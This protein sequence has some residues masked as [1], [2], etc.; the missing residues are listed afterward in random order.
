MNKPKV[1]GVTGGI[2]AG[3][4][5]VSKIFSSLGV[6]VYDADSNAKLLMVS[7]EE[8]KQSII[9]LFGPESYINQDL[10]REWIG[11]KAFSNPDLLKQLNHLVHPAVQRHFTKWVEQ[12]LDSRYVLKEAALLV[13]NES[14]KKLDH[15]IVVSAPENIRIER[16]LKR[17][18]HRSEEDVR[19]I[20]EKQLL[21]E[22]KIDKADFVLTNDGQSL[23][24]PE[25]LKLHEQ[26]SG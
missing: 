12:H 14:Y 23:L 15:L 2:G 22:E 17:D 24:I 1:V 5:L 9:D 25:I 3:K 6:P 20:L 11:K 7:D 4:S 10:N 19:A 26:F 13:E 18:S 16:V 8:L 21:E